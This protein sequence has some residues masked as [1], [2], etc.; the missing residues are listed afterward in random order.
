MNTNIT[1]KLFDYDVFFL[2]FNKHMYRKKSL[3]ATFFK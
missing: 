2:K 3:N 1:I